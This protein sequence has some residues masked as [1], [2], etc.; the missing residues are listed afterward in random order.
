MQRNPLNLL[1]R[2]QLLG[3]I[4]LDSVRSDSELSVL[5]FQGQQCEA[6]CSVDIEN[7]LRVGNYQN[8]S[9]VNFCI[10]GFAILICTTI[11]TPHP[12]SV[13]IFQYKLLLDHCGT[14]LQFVSADFAGA[15]M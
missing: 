15:T 7:G 4:R 13:P 2:I 10:V 1:A 8:V 12:C 14:N 9:L 6:M 3:F 11:S 5:I